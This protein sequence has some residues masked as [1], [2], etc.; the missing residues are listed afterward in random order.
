M[1]KIILTIKL[2]LIL[3]PFMGFLLTII[4]YS[5]S[6]LNQHIA[7][8]LSISDD[9]SRGREVITGRSMGNLEVNY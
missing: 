1:P 7:N 2:I 4:F 9:I 5:H 6:S 8:T 3:A